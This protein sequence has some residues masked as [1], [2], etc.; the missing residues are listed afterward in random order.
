M[1]AESKTDCYELSLFFTGQAVVVLVISKTTDSIVLSGS[2][3]AQMQLKQYM[4]LAMG[5]LGI[6]TAVPVSLICTY[7]LCIIAMAIGNE[8]HA[9]IKHDVW[10][11]PFKL[12]SL[13][14]SYTI[15][16][17]YYYIHIT[18]KCII[19][20]NNSRKCTHKDYSF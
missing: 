11:N 2:T 14:C 9:P 6:E 17:L 13:C 15:H 12:I 3:Q 1:R 7:I 18:N 4:S 20:R 10:L 5:S 19:H 8:S 16:S